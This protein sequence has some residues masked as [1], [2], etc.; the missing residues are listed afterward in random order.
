MSKYLWY[1]MS[2]KVNK[3]SH[4][5]KESG[6]SSGIGRISE[7][8]AVCLL[9]IWSR[10]PGIYVRPSSVFF[11]TRMYYF[12]T[13][14]HVP[15]RK[16]WM[17]KPLVKTWWEAC[18]D[19]GNGSLRIQRGE[20]RDARASQSGNIHTDKHYYG[21]THKRNGRENGR[22]GRG[23]LQ[24][25]GGQLDSYTRVSHFPFLPLQEIKSVCCL[26][27]GQPRAHLQSQRAN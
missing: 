26:L 9:E 8:E 18:L 21:R 1:N 6:P 17:V 2:L 7:N 20:S 12:N 19:L 3:C 4:F 22:Q 13:L 25:T 10:P 24:D 11:S 5:N 23:G 27:L 15:S 16:F 14:P